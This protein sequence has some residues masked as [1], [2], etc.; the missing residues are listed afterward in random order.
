[1]DD[2]FD[3]AF[4]EEVSAFLH[5]SEPLGSSTSVAN[6]DAN[7]DLTAP[8]HTKTDDEAE[9]KRKRQHEKKLSR[10]QRYERRL[11]EE[12][13]TLRKMEKLLTVQLVKIKKARD[14]EMMAQLSQINTV[15]RDLAQWERRQRRQSEEEQKKLVEAL[16]IQASYL[17][18]LQEL[19]P[20]PTK[21]LVM[22]T[23]HANTFTYH[24]EKQ[25]APDRCGC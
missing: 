22:N 24:T 5:A 6:L 12:R 9:L 4:L 8:S 11:K 10:K 15:I 16:T 14:N 2:S 13:Q 20:D 21:V 18:T 17:A 7:C 1:M 3:V 19:L 25:L 23:V